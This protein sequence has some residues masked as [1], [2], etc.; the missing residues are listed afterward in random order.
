VF[1]R[2][3]DD[4]LAE[5]L[6]DPDGI[7][8]DVDAALVDYADGDPEVLAQMRAVNTS[9]ASELKARAAN[10]VQE[11]ALIAARCHEV[12]ETPPSFPTSTQR[13]EVAPMVDQHVPP[14]IAAPC[15]PP[16]GRVALL[17]A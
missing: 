13:A 16:A 4:V 7:E 3:C 8:S 11:R 6:V 14:L 17:A 9:I 10:R 2:K 15:A 1:G 12:Y 5:V